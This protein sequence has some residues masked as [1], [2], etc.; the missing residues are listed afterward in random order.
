MMSLY[1]S[2]L[3]NLSFSGPTYFGPIIE[4]VSKMCHQCKATG[5]HIYQTLLILTDG[6]I[7]DMQKVVDLIIECA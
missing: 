2:S 1:A 6:Q 7:D 5:Q 3:K 4:H